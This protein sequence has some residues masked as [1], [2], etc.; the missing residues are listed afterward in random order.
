MQH[1][2]RGTQRNK[3]VRREG[4]MIAAVLLLPAACEGTSPPAVDFDLAE[5][6]AR[7]DP[8][9]IIG[10]PR[11]VPC[12]LSEGVES[13][14]VAVTLP[15]DP[16]A[17]D[18]GPWCPGHI[19]DPPEEGGIWLDRG[20]VWDVD[21]SFIENLAAFYD[22]PAWQMYDPA[23]GAVKVT[24]SR[25]ACAAAARPNVDPQYRNH[26]VQCLVSYVEAGITS[27]YVIPITPVGAARIAP[28]VGH[29]GVG[30]AYS[31]LRLDGPAP[32]D[33]ILSAYTLAPLDDCGGHVNLAAGYHVH[34]IT[35]CLSEQP[36]PGDH[37]PVI[38][39]ALDGHPLHALINPDGSVPEDLD[40]CRGHESD[41]EGY[42]YHVGAPGSNEILACHAGQTGC[43]LNDPDADCDATR[44][45]PPPPPDGRMRPPPP[46]G[47]ERGPPGRPPRPPRRGSD[48]VG[49]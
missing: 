21:G 25:E 13:T 7:F 33:A 23:T 41:A 45:R 44:I 43:V 19:N 12:T 49:A 46:P 11:L 15:A 9:A 6:A 1:R 10:A 22:D 14:C 30:L 2:R 34:A 35:D 42:H 37:A 16:A 32:T 40:S 47:P 36:N 26:C 31:G 27:T 28:R 24:G 5:F 38:G 39:L 20:R 8:G 48:G 3:R 4:T 17:F 18:I 29:E